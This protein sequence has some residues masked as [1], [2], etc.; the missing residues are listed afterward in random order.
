MNSINSFKKFFSSISII[1]ITLLTVSCGSGG[2]SAPATT[3]P[4]TAAT[5]TLGFEIK[6]FR[7][8]WSD[9]SD[10]TFYRVMENPDGV[11][12]FTQVS[13]DIAQGGGTF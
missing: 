3:T 8:T 13:G 7:F 11:S 10:A 4:V 1:C 2:D 6:T 12:G 5:A 9:V